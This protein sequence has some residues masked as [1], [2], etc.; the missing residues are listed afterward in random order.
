M[1]DYM[2]LHDGPFELDDKPLGHG[3]VKKLTFNLPNNFT[4]GTKYGKPILAYIINPRSDKVRVG[5]WVN[6]EPAQN[7]QL[8]QSTM[9]ESL[10]WTN[11]PHVDYSL[12][13][14]HSGTKF[15]VGK[16]NTIFFKTWDGHIRVRDV[17]LWYQRGSGT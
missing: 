2:V 16:E 9:N 12:W 15:N 3:D 8:K 1:T 6:P 11:L 7:P 10:S 13:D 5:I 17:V 4:V 14:A